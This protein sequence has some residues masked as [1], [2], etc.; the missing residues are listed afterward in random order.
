M[1]SRLLE[2]LLK[3]C[4]RGLMVISRIEIHLEIAKRMIKIINFRII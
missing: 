3:Y 2:H 1:K 4:F